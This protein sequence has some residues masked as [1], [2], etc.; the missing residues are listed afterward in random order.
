MNI[1]DDFTHGIIIKTLCP[2]KKSPEFGTEMVDE[3]LFGRKIKILENVDNNWYY[4]ETDYRY[5]GY[6]NKDYIY[7]N[8]K[9]TKNWM[10]NANHTVCWNIVDVMAEP[11]FQSYPLIRLTR[12][13]IIKLTGKEEEQ[14]V[15]ME[16]PQGG[17]G[18]LRKD[19][20]K[21]KV[22]IG[23]VYQEEDIRRKIVNTALSYMGTQYK[24]GGKSPL[25]IDCSGLCAISYLINGIIIYRDAQIK[26]EFNMRRI[27]RKD[28]KLGDMLY[29]PGHVAMYIGNEKYIHSTGKSSGVVINSLNAEDENY[30]EDLA[31]IKEV[32]TIF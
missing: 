11:K 14:W 18:W 13:A 3:S 12:G 27:K 6:V 22:S 32:G 7:V 20:V 9:K 5:K 17:K 26:E 28:M 29:W 24:W 8:D 10:E 21:E 23:S 16:F 2:L 31:D 25:G 15:Q 1:K 30:R 19:F 4:V